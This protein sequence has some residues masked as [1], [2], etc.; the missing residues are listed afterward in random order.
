MTARTPRQSD[1][2]GPILI[3]G[4]TGSIGRAVTREFAAAQ[5]SAIVL[6]S[7]DSRPLAPPLAA[8]GVAPRRHLNV[9]LNWGEELKR[10]AP[11][12]Q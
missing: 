8:E 5:W 9:W 6:G 4:G 2:R 1:S 10:L 7:V 11:P 3:T 12:V